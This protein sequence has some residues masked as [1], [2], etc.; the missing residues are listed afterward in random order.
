MQRV[1]PAWAELMRRL[2]YDSYT[3]HGGD[4]GSAISRELGLVDAEHVVA[5][6]LTQLLSASVTAETADFS[7]PAEGRSVE[8][9]YRY[10]YELGG[11]AMLQSSRPQTLSY[12]LTDSPSD[13]LP[14]SLNGSKTGPTQPTYPRTRSTARPCLPT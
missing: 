3:A 1:A 14:G 10:Q 5:L 4:F 9:G 6:H 12:A 2:G 7:D 8:Q 11:Y 13:S